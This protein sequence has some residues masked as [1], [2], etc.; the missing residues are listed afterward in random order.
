MIYQMEMS[1]CLTLQTLFTAAETQNSTMSFSRITT[2]A[3]MTRQQHLSC[4]NYPLNSMQTNVSLRLT[5]AIT[6][7]LWVASII[8]RWLHVYSNNL[9]ICQSKE[10]PW[11]DHQV[12]R[13]RSKKRGRSIGNR[14]IFNSTSLPTFNQRISPRINSKGSSKPSNT[15]RNRRLRNRMRH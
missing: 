10:A 5:W 13:L 1:R 8:T 6:W 3:A 15:Y 7:H 4:S 14:M 11:T 2:Q 12:P 9:I